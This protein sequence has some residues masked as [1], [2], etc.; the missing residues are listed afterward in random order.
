[1]IIN[2]LIVSIIDCIQHFPYF[3]MYFTIFILSVFSPEKGA[4]SPASQLLNDIPISAYFIAEQSLDPS[5][6]I[7]TIFPWFCKH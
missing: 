2:P 4:D 3:K 5:P 6:I 7:P 1:M